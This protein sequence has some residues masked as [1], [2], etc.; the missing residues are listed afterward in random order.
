MLQDD[1]N[2]IA[3]FDAPLAETRGIREAA[4][5][6]VSKSDRLGPAR[7]QKRAKRRF[8]ALLCER[9]QS[10]GNIS[11]QRGCFN[12]KPE[13]ALSDDSRTTTAGI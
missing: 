13:A 8:G 5:I 6:K 1:Q 2:Q 7:S 9:S 10:L 4:A 12:P 11:L 3:G